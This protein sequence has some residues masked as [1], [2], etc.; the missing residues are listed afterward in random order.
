MGENGVDT[1]DFGAPVPA[2][3]HPMPHPVLLMSRMEPRWVA[4]CEEF[5]KD[6][7][8]RA[9]AERAGYGK[10]SAATHAAW[11]IL[12]DDRARHVIRWLWR[13]KQQATR[14]E[15]DHIIDEMA[16]LANANIS[17]FVQWDEE[18]RV[19]W[20]ASESLTRSQKSAV[21]RFKR[22]TRTIPQKNADPITEV[23]VEIELF[24]KLSA[25]DKLAKVT[26]VTSSAIVGW[27]FDNATFTIDLGKGKP[28]SVGEIA[29]PEGP[30]LEAEVIPDDDAGSD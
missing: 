13:Q 29:A 5:I 20:T 8:K 30:V 28:A 25:L 11:R 16:Q 17:D 10:G 19:T 2:P 3:S 23:E 15:K 1:G 4:F 24:D 27:R 6:L 12:K 22:K 21:K 18:G 9:A 7:R 26:G 14:S